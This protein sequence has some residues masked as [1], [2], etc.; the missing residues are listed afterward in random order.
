MNQP[1]NQGTVVIFATSITS[2]YLSG[3]TMLF[4]ALA[5]SFI[6]RHWKVIFIEE[7]HPWLKTHTDFSARYQ[8]LSILCYRD[9]QELAEL[10]AQWHFLNNAKLVLKFSGSSGSY[11]R[12]ID[13]WL[14]YERSEANYR[15]SLVYVD[16]DAPM[17]LPYILSHPNFYLHK[18]IP[19]F[20][21]VWVM[22]GGERAAREYQA[23]KAQ[24]V[25]ATPAAIDAQAFRP[26]PPSKEYRADLLFIGNPTY[27]REERLTQLF[28]TVAR[29]CPEYRFF[30][31][32]ADW[33]GRQLPDN[34][35]FLGYVP[36]NRLPELY[37]SVRLVLN[38]TREEMASY[39]HAATLRL[40][41]AAA[42]GA[43]LISDTWLG[44]D[45]LFVPG[46]EILI[47]K[48]S[49]DVVNYLSR[50]ERRQS[51][52]IGVRARKR[53]IRDHTADKRVDQLLEVM[54][55]N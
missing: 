34:M 32:G 7:Y 46:E 13:E 37:S 48:S 43:C 4:R 49:D 27:G 45:Q 53:I 41:E 2:A 51:R 23:M 35:R 30:L 9:R 28:F 50:I 1:A 40:F 8:E 6:R 18:L 5:D 19:T 55:I 33:D 16:A 17:R 26:A 44:L 31:A 39:G 36:S 24:R 20:D 12:Y 15:F 21:G 38:V 25:W 52:A 14:A 3:G 10:Q 11:D 47:A 29:R 54:G 22:L 42:C